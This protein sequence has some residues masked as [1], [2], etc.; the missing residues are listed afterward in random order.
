MGREAKPGEGEPEGTG[1]ERVLYLD[2]SMTPI[3]FRVPILDTL[4]NLYQ[5]CLYSPSIVWG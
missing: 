5:E 3:L 1:R 4:M 2:E